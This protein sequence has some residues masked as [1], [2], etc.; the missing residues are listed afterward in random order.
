MPALDIATKA[1]EARDLRRQIAELDG[2]D[3]REIVFK[4]SSPRKRMATIYSMV[5]GE[6][7]KV[8][9][10]NIERVLEKRLPDGRYMFTADP[11][12]APEYKLGE[13]K[14]FLHPD[15]P[16]RPTL[17]SIGLG[18][19]YCPA[20]HLANNHS[21]RI[22][23]EHR[24]GQEWKAYQEHIKEE[25]ERADIERQNAQL[26]ATLAIAGRAAGAEKAELLKCPECDYEG[27]KQQVT[28][29]RAAKHKEVLHGQ[30][31]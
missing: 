19:A 23:A 6:P 24:H 27:T 5:D 4:E 7:L 3:E 8:A 17:V 18:G 11:Q 9:A 1:E 12:K 2:E 21:R 10:A 20:A 14:C 16:D 30:S 29:H 31:Q 26:E 28:G 25:K 15:S 22:H 13:V